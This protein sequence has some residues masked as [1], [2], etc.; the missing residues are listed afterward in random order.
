MAT[1]FSIER[2]ASL[3]INSS[4]GRRYIIS[5]ATQQVGQAN[6]NGTKLKAFPI[7]L[8]SFEEQQR[9]VDGHIQ[10]RGSV[11]TVLNQLRQNLLRSES[12][13][14]SLLTAAFSGRLTG[15]SSDMDVAEEIAAS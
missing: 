13:R 8:P 3:V 5:V 11:V 15:R 9:Q 2:W 14:R 12:M 10:V 1:C 7:P 4:Y 6:V